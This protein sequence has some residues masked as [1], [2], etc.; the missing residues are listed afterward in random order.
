MASG[1]TTPQDVMRGVAGGVIL[2]VPLIY[3]QETWLHGRTVHP[4]VLLAA[5]LVVLGI[6]VALSYF[7]GFR[8]GRTHRPVED[9]TV[10]MGISVL[11][12]AGLLVLLGRI[13]SDTSVANALGVVAVDAIAISLGF[14]VGAALAPV[15][16]GEGASEMT[17]GGGDLLVAAGGALVFA[18]NIAPTEEP[19][20]LAAEMGWVRLGLLVAISLLLP[21][22]IVFYAEF[23]GREARAASDGAT[24]GPVVETLLAY[25]VAFAV[26]GLMLA[27]FGRI[28]GLTPATLPVV[29]T[30]AFPASIGAALGRLLI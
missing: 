14:A 22:L 9:A 12:A 23:G 29:V 20:L 21:Y 5:F 25:A 10:G 24:Q 8:P 7:V 17:G 13:Q 30:L 15:G 27:M 2:G 3:T 16:G 28:E 26:S 4:F 11:L 18:L 1:A 19:I 6:D